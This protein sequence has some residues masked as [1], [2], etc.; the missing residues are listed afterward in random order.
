MLS[1]IA[2][3]SLASTSGS[4]ENRHRYYGV[5]TIVPPVLRSYHN[6]ATGIM[7]LPLFAISTTVLP[8]P[9]VVL[10]KFGLSADAD[11]TVFEIGKI[12]TLKNLSVASNFS[13]P[14]PDSISELMSMQSSDLTHNSLSG[15]LPSSLTKLNN[16]VYLNLSVNGF[17]KKIPKGFELMA[18]LEVLDLHGN[19]LDGSLDPEFLLLTTSTYVDSSGNL[20][21]SFTSQYQKFLSGISTG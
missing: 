20:L 5:T 19:M 14:I 2:K 21:V 16:L 11:L 3:V 9:Q 18:N 4:R 7:V 1:A 12:G 8:P 17:T 13:G 6:R 15:P 10:D